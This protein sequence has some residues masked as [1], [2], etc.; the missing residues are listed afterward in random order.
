MDLNLFF[1][2]ANGDFAI[3]ADSTQQEIFIHQ[4]SKPGDIHSTPLIGISLV[5]FIGSPST[6]TPELDR[7]TRQSL[8]SDGFQVNRVEFDGVNLY[9]DADR[10]KEAK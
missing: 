7:R 4:V 1:P 10:G 9:V 8:G 5:D 6:A 3:V 2:F